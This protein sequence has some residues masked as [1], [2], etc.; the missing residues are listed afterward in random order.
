[1]KR[2]LLLLVTSIYILSCNNNA[3]VKGKF[4]ISGEIKNVPDQKIY[5]EQ[6]YFS[7]KNPEIIDTAEIKN[8]K[9]TLSASANEEGL[10]R[11]RTEKMGAGFI[12]I[13]DNNVINFKADINDVSLDGPKFDTRAN[14]ILKKLVL[15]L[16]EKSRE[17]SACDDRLDS[18]V[19]INDSTAGIE[20]NKRDV[21][22]IL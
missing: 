14:S 13:N 10:Y 20:K 4:L 15:N 7:Q 8:G 9:F 21:R 16:D 1:M 3:V 11:I 19:K 2:I 22:I 5:L 6:L 17:L 18:L 12:F